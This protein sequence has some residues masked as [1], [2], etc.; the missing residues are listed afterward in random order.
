MCK[1]HLCCH[2]CVFVANKE[3]TAKNTSISSA[4]QQSLANNSRLWLVATPNSPHDLHMYEHTQLSN[5]ADCY[6]R[7]VLCIVHVRLHP[8]HKATWTGMPQE[9][10][11]VHT[12]MR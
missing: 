6:S 11:T 12:C 1:A 10:C 7:V 5:D 2:C 9:N 8:N 3:D 4:E